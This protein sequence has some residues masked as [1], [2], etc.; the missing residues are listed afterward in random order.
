MIEIQTLVL[1]P[2][3]TNCYLV[4]DSETGV[5]AVIDPSWSGEQIA[6]EI[7]KRRW[8]VKTILLTHAHFDHFGGCGAVA[9]KTGAPVAMHRGDLPLWQA[10]GG[11]MLF[12]FAKV[13]QG[14]EPSVWLEPGQTVEVGNLRFEVL[15]LPGHT[16]GHVGFHDA[17]NRRLF[18]GDVIFEGSIG[19]TDFP[20]GSHK[21]L[22][23]SIRL[24]VLTLPDDTV[25]YP[26]HG[27]ATTVGEERVSNPFLAE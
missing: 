1:G 12:G 24:G 3:Q 2:A 17:A 13:D 21:Q 11:A 7:E 22:M 25:I 23:E 6:A 16:P 15:F 26:G 9:A 20:G 19:R 18:S 27:P 14:P 10:K 8:S 5:A 4:A